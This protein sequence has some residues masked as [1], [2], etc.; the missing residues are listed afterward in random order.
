MRERPR[1]WPP[2]S[3]RSGSAPDPQSFSEARAP[4]PQ[5]GWSAPDGPVRP[6]ASLVRAT[7]PPASTNLGEA[8]AALTWHVAKVLQSRRR[9][10]GCPKAGKVASQP[11]CSSG[12][13][14]TLHSP[15]DPAPLLPGPDPVSW[16]P[17]HGGRRCSRWQ[18]RTHRIR[19]SS[20]VR[21]RAG[22]CRTQPGGAGPQG[23]TAGA[24]HS[25]TGSSKPG[26]TTTPVVTRWTGPSGMSS[27]GSAVRSGSSAR[28]GR[29]WQKPRPSSPGRPARSRP[30]LRVVSAHQAI[31]P[32]ATMCRL[33]GRLLC[34]T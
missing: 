7:R 14:L 8:F 23:G 29:S 6:A 21:G 26:V 3:Q 32:I 22:R 17:K 16:T 33:P 27:A 10:S 19:G 1:T 28:S 11:S 24:G 4:I 18:R 9:S 25:P 15:S 31:Y 34:M 30:G 12:N 13:R 5:R 2:G 20:G